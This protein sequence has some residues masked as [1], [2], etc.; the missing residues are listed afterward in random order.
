MLNG[1]SGQPLRAYWRDSGTAS[2]AR[3]S[4]A[5]LAECSYRLLD[6]GGL[7][8]LEVGSG[9]QNAEL[10]KV[11]VQVEALNPAELRKEVAAEVEVLIGDYTLVLL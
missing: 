11:A 2:A 10:A 3:E 7:R 1:Q 4:S 9:I 5:G 6:S 8:R